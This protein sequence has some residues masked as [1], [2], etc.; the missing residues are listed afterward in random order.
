MRYFLGFL[1]C[2]NLASAQTAL[3]VRDSDTRLAP[4]ALSTLLSGH[5]VRF[6]DGGFATFGADGQYAY[7]Y[8]TGDQIWRGV[9]EVQE[10]SRVCV[11]F[12]NGFSR[13]DTYIKDGERL[14]LITDKGDRYPAKSIDAQ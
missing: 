8:D 5:I 13:C 9:Y 6:H 7:A 12:E 11:D 3:G 4:A 2:A 14:I 10:D 1:L